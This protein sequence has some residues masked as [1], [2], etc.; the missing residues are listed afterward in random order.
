MGSLIARLEDRIDEKR[1][2]STDSNE[3]WMYF[4]S[5]YS[6]EEAGFQFEVTAANPDGKLHIF[7]LETVYFKSQILEC[8]NIGEYWNISGVPV[9]PEN[10]VFTFIRMC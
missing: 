8:P 10:V 3:M 5:D 6:V 9:L 7:L 2:Y 4:V 1:L